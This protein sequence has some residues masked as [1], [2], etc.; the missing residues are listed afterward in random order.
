[1]Y[2]SAP[3]RPANGTSIHAFTSGS[4][5]SR[6][7]LMD[8]LT[9]FVINHWALVAGFVAVLGMLIA[10]VAVTSGGI[11]PQSAVILMNRERAVAV[12]VRTAAEFAG[13][14]IIDAV[15]LPGEAMAGAAETLKSMRERPLLVYC[16]TGT[17]AGRAARELKKLGFAKVSALKGGLAAWRA[18]NLPVTTA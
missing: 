1:M 2:H 8:Q 4:P 5:R 15:H 10:S 18:E 6:K 3:G 9:E 7:T 17:Q 13:G 16:A 12:D 14:H 11:T